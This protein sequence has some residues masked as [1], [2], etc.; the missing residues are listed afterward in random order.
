MAVGH[1][2]LGRKE[3]RDLLGKA[4]AGIDQPTRLRIVVRVQVGISDAAGRFFLPSET[5]EGAALAQV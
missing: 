1:V 2:G 3:T 4:A 5:S